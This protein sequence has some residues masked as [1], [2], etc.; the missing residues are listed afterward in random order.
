[1]EPSGRNQWQPVANG[2]ALKLITLGTSATLLSAMH[3]L[4]RPRSHSYRRAQR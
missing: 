1:M 3:L 2:K 4:E